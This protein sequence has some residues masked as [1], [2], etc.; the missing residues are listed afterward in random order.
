MAGTDRV[1]LITRPV[2]NAIAQVAAMDDG[3]SAPPETIHQQLR[4]FIDASRQEGSRLGLSSQDTDDI[5]YALVALADEQ[6]LLRGG[7]LRDFWLPRMLQ[8]QYFNE[9]VAGENFFRR[10]SALISDPSRSAIL[11]VYYLCML[12]GF[13]GRYRVRG[14]SAEI[15]ALVDQVH[16]ALRRAGAVVDDVVLSPSGARPYESITDSRRN[17]LVLW[18]AVVAAAASVVAYLWLRLDIAARAAE[19]VERIGALSGG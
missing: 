16:A 10:L 9:N 5:V 4:A 12:F 8:L 2:F 1:T 11:K 13:Q 14:G 15:D 6:V 17:A 7:P 19:L 18:V 3:S